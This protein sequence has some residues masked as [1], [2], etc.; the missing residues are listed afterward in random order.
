MFPLRNKKKT[1]SFRQGQKYYDRIIVIIYLE[2]KLF[3]YT[4][5]ITID[6][7]EEG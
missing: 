2:K 3:F 6:E 7:T 1:W 5:S 4:L